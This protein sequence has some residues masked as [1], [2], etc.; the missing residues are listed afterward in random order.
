MLPVFR[1]ESDK[2]VGV[3]QAEFAAPE[4]IH[5]DGCEA[6]DVRVTQD[7]LPAHEGDVIGAGDMALGGEAGGVEKVG[8]VHPQLSRPLVHFFHKGLGAARQML[9]QGY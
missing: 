9:R 4:G 8:V 3:A 6:A 2:L 5:P 7:Q 1:P